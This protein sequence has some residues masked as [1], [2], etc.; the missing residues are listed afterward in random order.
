MYHISKCLVRLLKTK[1]T[2]LLKLT[3]KHG[4]FCLY[5][6][7]NFVY[8]SLKILF[9]LCSLSV[10][11]KPTLFPTL[12]VISRTFSMYQNENI[13]VWLLH[14]CR[15]KTL[16]IQNFPSSPYAA[17]LNSTSQRVSIVEHP[18]RDEGHCVPPGTTEQPASSRTRDCHASV[19]G[20]AMQP[21]RFKSAV[22]S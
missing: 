1:S 13:S 19:Q 5:D 14:I 21:Q 7:A 8:M 17:L 4:F 3:L 6:L 12:H 2:T 22:I 15:H 9:N 11:W 20:N 18:R 10:I 16:E